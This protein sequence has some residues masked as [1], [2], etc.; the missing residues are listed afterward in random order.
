MDSSSPAQ[1][2]MAWLSC[3]TCQ[4]SAGF[5]GF[6]LSQA[7][8]RVRFSPDGRLLAATCDDGSVRIIHLEMNHEWSHLKAD[9]CAYRSL[10]FSPDGH[11]LATAGMGNMVALWDTRIW[12]IAQRFHLHSE[13][14]D[15]WAPCV[16]FDRAGTRL[17]AGGSDGV[18]RI[19]NPATSALCREIPAQDSPLWT[20]AFHL[21][22]DE[23]VIGGSSGRITWH[24]LDGERP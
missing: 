16:A 13:A 17:A 21:V 18:A 3:G 1:A 24:A 23:L 7:V 15:I 10:A 19:W 9:D 14:D 8:H 12:T 11:Y 2:G 6:D 22:R 20:L 4:I 5:A